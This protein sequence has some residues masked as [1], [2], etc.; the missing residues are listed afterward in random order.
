M[1]RWRGGPFYE[2]D[3]ITL[4]CQFE[5]DGTA[6]APDTGTALCTIYKRG[7][8]DP[9]VD[10]VTASI[11]GTTISY[12]RADLAVGE[13][14]AYITAKFNTGADERTGE[15]RFVVLDKGAIW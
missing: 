4:K 5:S 14:V 3:D 9:I 13:Y 10:A 1:S 8:D 6:Q 11:S 15:I 7:T 12:K 2:N